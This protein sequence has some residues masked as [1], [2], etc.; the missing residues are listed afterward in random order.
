MAPT[1]TPLARAK[2]IALRQLAARAR[3]EAQLR[4]RLDRDGLGGEADAVIAW[5]RALRYVDDEAYARAR[6]R[7]LVAG[8][9]YG[10][11][12]ATQR[13][14]REG[15]SPVRARAVLDEALCETG[16]RDAAAAEL[17]LCR[18]L[19]LRRAR[20]RPPAELDDRAR[21]RLARFL[22]GRGF[23]GRAVSAVLGVYVDGD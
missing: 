7:G 1:D 17:A 14:V 20:G 8:G 16:S 23:S 3:T 21:A 6:A 18:A 19:A 5:L 2:A 9:R 22:S 15:I 13:L 4:A 11:R 10:P 12:Q